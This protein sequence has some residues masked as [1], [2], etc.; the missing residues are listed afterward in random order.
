VQGASYIY[1]FDRGGFNKTQADLL[2]T[3][4]LSYRYRL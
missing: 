4:G 1:N 3:G 2:W